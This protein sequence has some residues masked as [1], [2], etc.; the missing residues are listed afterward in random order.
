MSDF[1]VKEINNNYLSL[2]DELIENYNNN[3][4]DISQFNRYLKQINFNYDLDKNDNCVFNND[5]GNFLDIRQ[6][7]IDNTGKDLIMKNVQF[8]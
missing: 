1:S 5:V 7:I 3:K 2:L 6:Y 8:I 4:F